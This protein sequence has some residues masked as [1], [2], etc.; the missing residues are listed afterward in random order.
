MNLNFP[1]ASTARLHSVVGHL[2]AITALVLGL[3]A[4]SEPA[5]DTSGQGSVDI[6]T[7]FPDVDAV[8][9]QTDASEDLFDPDQFIVD[10]KPCE[11]PGAWGCTCKNN[12]DCNSGFCIDSSDGKICTKTCTTSCPQDWTCA[13]TS[14]TELVYVCVP[15]Y[16]NL[17]KPCNSHAECSTSGLSGQS[18]CI[19]YE[20]TTGG[21]KFIDGSFCGSACDTDVDCKDG[22]ECG[23]V[24]VVAADGITP[25]T[26]KQCLPKPGETGKRECGCTAAWAGTGAATNCEKSNVYGTCKAVRVC[27]Q[28]SP[29]VY[30]L[31]LC[32]S[33]TPEAEI[34]DGQDNDCDGQTDEDGATGCTV[35]YDDNDGDFFG[36]GLGQC[37]CSD[38]G[39]GF[40]KNGGDCNDYDSS[41][42]PS[43]QELCDSKDNNCNGNT[44]EAGSQG[45]KIYYADLDG[46][47]FG[48]DNNS[49]CMC[50]SKK[51][52][53]YIETPGDC[54][55]GDKN[56]RP[57][58]AEVCDEADNDCDNKVDE[59][60]ADGCQLFFIDADK[61]Q[62]G[63]TASGKC[64]CK[65]N[66]LYVTNNAGDCDDNNN[67]IT[68]AAQELCNNID[69]DCSG[70]TDDGIASL[71]CPAVDG[72]NAACLAGGVC[73]VGKCANKKFDVNED[74][75]DGCECAADNNFG[76]KGQSCGNYIDLGDMPDGAGT[77]FASGNIMPGEGGDWYHFYAKDLIDTDNGCDAHNVRVKFASNPEEQYLFDVYRGSCAAGDQVCA[78]ETDHSWGTSF[79]GPMPGQ[80]GGPQGD[81]SGNRSNYS[82][83]AQHPSGKSPVPEKYGECKCV[84]AETAGNLM[85]SPGVN[86]CS[87]NSAHYF[88]RVFRKPG[89]AATCDLYSLKVDNSP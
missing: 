80:N 13:Q 34:C 77:K 83:A 64:L 20:T 52:A 79:Y 45:C 76:L 71:T 1:Q 25:L 22:F 65:G 41:V 17:C 10:D 81:K 66:L 84:T 28:A 14:G 78:N 3:V 56:I 27:A 35:F 86:I 54:N 51:T 59:E 70:V 16:S 7:T 38:P 32:A 23:T 44:D 36:I 15:A 40:T 26:A 19:P 9:A 60:G 63:P 2:L 46:D 12:N 72:G 74:P 82:N 48:D 37:L 39:L 89:V 75:S 30:S 69:D 61:D 57:G 50:A 49:A 5:E 21:N 68:P 53:N 67:Q 88:V 8:V 47:K 62:Y 55:D 58:V 18:L 24:T 33:N 4:C 11:S 6:G 87:D 73:G 29:N 43:A 42:K 31:T 85:S